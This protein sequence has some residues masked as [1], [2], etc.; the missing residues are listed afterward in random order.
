[1]N[2]ACTRRLRQDAGE[3]YVAVIDDRRR[4][5][6][7]TSLAKRHL[8]HTVK[9]PRGPST[10][11]GHLMKRVRLDTLVA[12]MQISESMAALNKRAPGAPQ[13]TSGEVCL[14]SRVPRRGRGRRPGGRGGRPKGMPCWES[15]ATYAATSGVV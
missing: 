2:P 14:A 4:V 15:P 9:V 6:R 13:L 5:W 8:L 7:P 3:G 1:M 12:D 10:S 11:L